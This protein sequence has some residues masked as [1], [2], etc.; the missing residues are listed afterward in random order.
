MDFGNLVI[1]NAALDP[2]ADAK[3]DP[4]TDSR[5]DIDNESEIEL[6]KPKIK[7]KFQPRNGRKGNTIIENL[8]HYVGDLKEFNK[9]HKL[10]N[11]WGTKVTIKTIDDNYNPVMMLNG[12]RISDIQEFLMTECKIDK[13]SINA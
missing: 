5:I 1:S 11:N 7:I 10:G 13:S 4:F 6:E 8:F 2:F 9:K 3:D 12:N